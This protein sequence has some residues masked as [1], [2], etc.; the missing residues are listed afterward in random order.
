MER[1]HRTYPRQRSQKGQPVAGFKVALIIPLPLAP[2][3]IDG[4]RLS[5]MLEDAGGAGRR[6]QGRHAAQV[7]SLRDDGIHSAAD[8]SEDGVLGKS[9]RVHWLTNILRP[10]DRQAVP[11]AP[12]RSFQ[13]AKA[14][15]S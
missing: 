8:H 1:Q 12:Q 2:D 7:D 6:I 3:V 9:I 10:L 15:D 14:I 5:G 4:K 11:S 13:P